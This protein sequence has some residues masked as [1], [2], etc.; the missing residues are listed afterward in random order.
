M[1]KTDYK[2][3]LSFELTK[4]NY[5]KYDVK[6]ENLN[7]KINTKKHYESL[8]EYCY[9]SFEGGI[10]SESYFIYQK[11]T[12]VIWISYR[13]IWAKIESETKYNYGEIKKILIDVFEKNFNLKQI[14]PY[15]S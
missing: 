4:L 11:I 8:I 2:K 10:D 13:F 14:I 6:V 7:L 9:Y 12:N 3:I 15:P 5:F 1:K